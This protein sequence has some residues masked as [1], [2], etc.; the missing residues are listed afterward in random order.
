MD[1]KRIVQRDNILMT[2]RHTLQH[3]DLV[4]YLS[5]LRYHATSDDKAA[6]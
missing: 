2:A 5:H 1:L 4:E 6:P 3:S